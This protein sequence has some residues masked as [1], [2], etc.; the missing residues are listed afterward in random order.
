MGN[1]RFSAATFTAKYDKLTVLYIQIYILN[2][3]SALIFSSIRESYMV[4][5]YHR[6]TPPFK[7]Q[8]AAETK[9]E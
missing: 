3:T 1:C 2:P 6:L 5:L 7:T 9:T 4:N 8:F